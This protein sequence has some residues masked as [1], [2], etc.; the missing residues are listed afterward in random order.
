VKQTDI[1]ILIY[2]KNYSE[3]SLILT[4]FTENKGLATYIFKGAKK[5]Q[6]A[7]FALG[8][9]EITYFKRPESD[10]GI[11]NSMDNAVPLNDFFS[12]PQ[13]IILGFFIA[14]ILKQTIKME[15]ADPSLF[16]FLKNQILVLESA[17]DCFNFPLH[18]LAGLTRELG[19]SPL[20]ESDNP[21][22]FDIKKGEFSDFKSINSIG[23]EGE[24]V[25]LLGS[26]FQNELTTNYSNETT[27]K[28]LYIL[29]EYLTI[30]TPKFNVAKSMEVIRDTL[31]V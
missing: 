19:Y 28:A 6:K 8:I 15:E 1:G 4:F 14:D 17:Q 22:S 16:E 29:L 27:K 5:K 21:I 30:H 26:L 2:R 10:M 25:H 12:N 9:Y 11:I 7:I 3:S 20:F 24:V 13:K 18:F 23:I 31:Y